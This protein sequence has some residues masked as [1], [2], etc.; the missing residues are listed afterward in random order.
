[1]SEIPAWP[2]GFETTVPKVAAQHETDISVAAIKDRNKI[3]GLPSLTPIRSGEL[4]CT[5]EGCQ[6]THYEHRN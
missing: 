4:R 1:M 3:M 6:L 2:T 5:I